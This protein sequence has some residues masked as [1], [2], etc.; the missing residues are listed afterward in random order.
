[1]NSKERVH[2]ALAGQPV[3]RNPVTALYNMLYHEDHFEELTGLPAAQAN[4]WHHGDPEHYLAL[5]SR[6]IEQAP[7]ELLQPHSAPTR[8][9]RERMEWIDLNGKHFWRDRQDGGLTPVPDPISGHGKD[10]VANQ[11]Q[12]VFD[13]ADADARIKLRSAEE[14]IADGV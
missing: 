4:A 5:Y 7:L 2:A 13:R 14:Q 3:D 12:Y 10:D 8:A 1:M 11:T 9:W 6:M